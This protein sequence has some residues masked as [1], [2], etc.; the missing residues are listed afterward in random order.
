M[1]DTAVYSTGRVSC[2]DP[3][4]LRVFWAGFFF[5]AG[6]NNSIS[7]YNEVNNLIKSFQ[8]IFT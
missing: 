7:P 8:T 6:S 3:N 5:F 1:C 2:N 4:P